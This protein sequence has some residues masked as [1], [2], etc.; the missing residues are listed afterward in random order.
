L[1]ALV[2]LYLLDHPV[3]TDEQKAELKDR[4]G[5]R[6]DELATALTQRT[7][8][9]A[10]PAPRLTPEQQAVRRRIER[11]RRRGKKKRGR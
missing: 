9:R 2:Q 3:P 6:I 11:D 8:R 7:R 5:H 1:R 10:A 4:I